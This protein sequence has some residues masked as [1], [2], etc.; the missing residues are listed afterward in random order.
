MKNN[1]CK[2]CEKFTKFG[3]PCVIDNMSDEPILYPERTKTDCYAYRYEDKKTNDAIQ[4]AVEMNLTEEG[5]KQLMKEYL[6][7]IYNDLK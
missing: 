3:K 1:I 5:H 4:R 6:E 7:N 2:T